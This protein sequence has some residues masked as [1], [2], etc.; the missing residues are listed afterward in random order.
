MQTQLGITL[1]DTFGDYFNEYWD[2]DY[3]LSKKYRKDFINQILKIV[4]IIQIKFF[5]LKIGTLI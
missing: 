3:T 5:I 2:K 4:L 1:I